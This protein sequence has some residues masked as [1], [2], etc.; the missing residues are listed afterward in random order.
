MNKTSSSKPLKEIAKIQEQIDILEHDKKK[1]WEEITDTYL[2]LSLAV[3]RVDDWNKA[4]EAAELSMKSARKIKDKY[5]KSFKISKASEEIGSIYE[6]IEDYSKA[7]K[8]FDDAI[9]SIEKVIE[10]LIKEKEKLAEEEFTK[11][12]TLTKSLYVDYLKRKIEVL[13]TTNDEKK[14]R[15]SVTKLREK[16]L[17][18]KDPNYF[19]ILAYLADINIFLAQKLRDADLVVRGVGELLI[20]DFFAKKFSDTD[21]FWSNKLHRDL[22]ENGK[23]L[24]EMFHIPLD[25]QILGKETLSILKQIELETKDHMYI[26]KILELR[27]KE[28]EKEKIDN[29]IKTIAQI[30]EEEESKA[31]S[32]KMVL[33][34][35]Q[36]ELIMSLAEENEYTNALEKAKNIIKET[37]KIKNPFVK[38]FMLGEIQLNLFRINVRR[39]DYKQAEKEAKKAIDFFEENI[40]TISHACFTMLELASCYMIQNRF[41]K[42]E[43]MLEKPI[44][45]CEKSGSAELLARLYELLAGIKLKSEEYDEAAIYFSASAVFYLISD[46]Q[47]KYREFITLAIN[48]FNEYLKT[49]GFEG[50][51]FE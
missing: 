8:Y 32:A 39:Q 24:L 50:V 19:E 34:M 14:A 36:N 26:D 10:N 47:D 18:T 37:K 40:N 23:I 22:R 20:I 31:D 38:N 5:V 42:A 27:K 44:D 6:I 29:L 49:I 11:H 45:L 33:S 30:R 15:E 21:R 46:D 3:K 9:D 48:L 41:D 1:N 4:I 2:A 43:S 51:Q 28:T 13:L 16:Y 12:S 17:K 35:A 7:T 25:E